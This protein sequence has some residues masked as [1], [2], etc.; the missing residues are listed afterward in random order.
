MLTRSELGDTAP[1]RW[2]K[3]VTFLQISLISRSSFRSLLLGKEFRMPTSNLWTTDQFP[4]FKFSK[5]KNE[6]KYQKQNEQQIRCEKWYDA[7]PRIKSSLPK[8]LAPT[9]LFWMWVPPPGMW[10][11]PAR[12]QGPPAQILERASWRSTRLPHTQTECES[13]PLH[14]HRR[15]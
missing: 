11:P 5:N 9:I 1:R 8:H 12:N 7:R 14:P 10:V 2:K 6:K 3:K 15:V 13:M 4:D